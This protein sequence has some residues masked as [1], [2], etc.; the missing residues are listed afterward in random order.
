MYVELKSIE[1][2]MNKMDYKE[3]LPRTCE[4]LRVNKDWFIYLEVYSTFT[5]TPIHLSIHPS[6]II[7]HPS[8]C[9]PIYPLSFTIH[10]FVH[11]SIYLHTHPA[12]H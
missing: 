12:I 9:L 1:E 10:P 7:Y 2:E 5:H 3:K 11:P 8:I 6:I 4:D